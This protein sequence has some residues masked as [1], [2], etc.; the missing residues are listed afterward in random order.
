MRHSDTALEHL[1]FLPITH[2]TV[3]VSFSHP[4]T[5]PYLRTRRVRSVDKPRRRV[6]HH[7][8]VRGGVHHHR[9]RGGRHSSRP[10]YRQQDVERHLGRHRGGGRGSLGVSLARPILPGKWHRPLKRT[11]LQKHTVQRKRFCFIT[12]QGLRAVPRQQR[13]VGAR[14]Y[15]PGVMIPHYST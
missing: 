2:S 5:H 11:A 4:L 14:P 8:A 6:G 3:H 12:I 1:L 15:Q 10:I 9:G 13:L 7:I